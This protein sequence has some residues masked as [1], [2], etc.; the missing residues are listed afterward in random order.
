MIFAFPLLGGTAAYFSFRDHEHRASAALSEAVAVGEENTA[1][2]LDTHVLVAE[3]IDDLLENRTDAEISADE[4]ALHEQIARQIAGLP[5][6]AAAWVIG[7]DAR[8]QVS[9]RVFPVDREIDQSQREDFRAL[10]DPGTRTYIRALRAR[11]LDGGDYHA[12]FTVSLRRR[13]ADDHFRGIIVVA[14]SGTYVGS[15]YNSLLAGSSQYTASVIREDGTV[16]GTYPPRPTA[17][18]AA[19]EQDALAAAIAEKSAIGSIETGSV[20]DPR[21]RLISYARLADYPVY[22]AIMRS[23]AAVFHEWLRSIAGYVVVCVPASIALI[24]LTLV[25]LRRARREQLALAQARD[26]VTERAEAEARLHQAQKLEAVGLITAGIAHD[27]NNM[28][29]VISGNILLLQGKIEQLSGLPQKYLTAA[30]AGCERANELTKRL[31]GFTYQEPV[32]PRPVD[33][34]QII[35]E[36]L[37]LPWQSNGKIT[38]AFHLSKP[39]WP[40]Y[41]DPDQ[42]ANA[43]LYL[44]LYAREAMPDGGRLTIETANRRVDKGAMPRGLALVAG[45]YVTVA[46]GDTGI[47]IPEAIRGRVF[48]PFFTSKEPGKGTGLGL[49]Q[50]E[51]FVARSGGACEIESE[52]DCG[53]VFR[54]YLPRYVGEAAGREKAIPKYDVAAK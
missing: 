52:P 11:R 13:S 46:V 28:L 54:L 41:V 10:Q 31:L 25:A 50:V 35:G 7:A 45:D 14:V 9:A 33:I 48:D 26:A 47:G 27:F 2:I 36:V 44:T 12:F 34:N 21:G 8:E 16:L 38:T 17:A 42:L 23:R 22:V 49:A 39:I 5:Q 43:L 29:T 15:F 6:V 32:D 40:T 20:F 19:L 53:T 30:I 37:D 4:S 3:R 18:P 51:G 1:K 24:L